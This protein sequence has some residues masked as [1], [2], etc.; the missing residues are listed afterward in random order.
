MTTIQGCIKEIM[1]CWPLELV[2]KTKLGQ[3]E[4]VTLG[5]GCDIHQQGHPISPSEIEIGA[6]VTCL[7][8]DKD[9]I[10]S[11]LEIH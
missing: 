4:P 11:T 7:T 5:M 3:L 9:R 6:E 8:G 2:I 1:E 10:V